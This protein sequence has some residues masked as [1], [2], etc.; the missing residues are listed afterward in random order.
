M[1]LSNK[2]LLG[3]FGFIFLYLTAAFTEIRL[4]GSPNIINDENSIAE[5]VDLPA[6]TYLVLSGVNNN[7]NV[8]GSDQLRLE[9][10]SIAGD[11]L[12]KLKYAVS[13]DTLTLSG[14]DAGDHKNFK[15]TVFVPATDFKAIHANGSR[16][17]IKGLHTS[18]LNIELSAGDVSVSDCNIAKL[19]LNLNAAQLSIADATVESVSVDTESSTVNI[20]SPLLRLQGSLKNQSIL[21]LQD[22]QDIQLSKDESSR[23]SLYR[24]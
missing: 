8:I 9:L 4:T 24:Y 11:V 15:I 10:R 16:V 5:T 12:Q 20:H 1:K 7:I 6:I 21:L 23:L 19:E 2:I 14:I 3:F 18:L 17:T 13:G 22:A